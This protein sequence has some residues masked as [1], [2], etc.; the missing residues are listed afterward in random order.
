MR[1]AISIPQYVGDDGEFDRDGFRS[2]L[3]RAEELGFESGWVQEQVL[4]PAPS[5]SPLGALTYAAACTARLRLGCAVFVT[6]LHSPV[7]L[8][9]AIS[10]LD[11]LS[12]GRVEVGIGTG[13][14]ARPFAAFGIDGDRLVARFTEGL[15]LMKACWTEPEINFDGRFWQLA[16]AAMEPKPVQ[17]PHP[18]VWIGGNHPAAL[19]R[20]VRLG[21]GFFGAGSQPTA[22]FAEQARVV[23]D[24]LAR[25]GR[26]PT[27]FRIAK[28]VYIHV[29]DDPAR[30]H[31]RIESA[32]ARHYGQPVPG[33]SIS[34]PPKACV[35][36]LREVADAG[37]DLILLNPLVEDHEQMERLAAEVIPELA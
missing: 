21:D 13:G 17:K 20:A 4:G 2:H 34:G 36:A 11:C 18:P 7:H 19:A 8:A 5:L 9:Y 35:A 24:E 28:R 29:G 31:D 14:R 33:V 26:D 37:P 1:F 27:T 10:T 22:A 30:A 16:G 6:P 3:A 25:R 32:L 15:A 12:G 23:R